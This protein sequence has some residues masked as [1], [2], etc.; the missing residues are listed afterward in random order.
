MDRIKPMSECFREKFNIWYKLQ[1]QKKKVNITQQQQNR[2][3]K[4]KWIDRKHT[5]IWQYMKQLFPIRKTTIIKYHN[6][7]SRHQR[8]NGF[9]LFF[10]IG[11]HVSLCMNGN[12][13]KWIIKNRTSNGFLEHVNI[14]QPVWY[15][16]KLGTSKLEKIDN[17]RGNWITVKTWNLTLSRST[18]FKGLSIGSWSPSTCIKHDQTRSMSQRWG[19]T[20]IPL[21]PFIEH[22]LRPKTRM[23]SISSERAKEGKQSLY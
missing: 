3:N 8:E 15:P 17:V 2:I 9:L 1:S 23:T 18:F 11:F 13:Y 14:I 5:V 22:D 21:T 12:V 19:A 4:R 20:G 6:L 16:S 10:K 7:D